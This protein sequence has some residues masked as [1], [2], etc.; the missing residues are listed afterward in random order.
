MTSTNAYE[1]NV[2][3]RNILKFAIPTIIMTIFMSFYTMVD[4]LFVS[5]LLGTDALSAINLTAPIIALVTAVSTMLA[6]DGSAL[7]MKKVGE[8]KGEE[9][10]QDFTFLILVN[11]VVGAIMT[12]VAYL[13]MD[14]IFLSMDL[15]STTFNYCHDYLSH[16]LFFVI[17]ILLMNNFTLYMIA[18]G[19]SNLSILCSI[20][21]GITNIILDYFLIA[22]CHMGIK[23]AAIATGIGYSITAIV[24][25]YI[26][27]KKTEMI[28]FT[29]LKCRLATLLKA[30]TNGSSE[31]ATA[32]VTG[33]T[34]MLFNA[35]MLY[36]V[37][38]D[39][40]AA[41]TIIMY[42]LMFAT[43]LYTGYAYGV[44]PMISYYHGQQNH[45]KLHKLINLSLKI[46]ATVAL[47]SLISSIALTK[48]LV[49]IFT[50]VDNPV[51]QLAVNGNQLCSI[52]IIFIGFN[53]FVSSLFT[54][55][56]NGLISAVIAFSRS[57][58][59]MIIALITLPKLLGINGIWL[60]TPVAELA[61]FILASIMFIIFKKRYRY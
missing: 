43:S 34:T 17:A 49:S 2:N 47:V 35:S 26:F 42:V 13:L 7:I 9:A 22:K 59:F 53:I 60:A 4:G 56:S 61:S 8:G 38:E 55:L 23:G 24:G 33:I 6:S 39:G 27:S 10:K 5:N 58:V 40:V 15:S 36:Y 52:A 37:G 14:K 29:K 25:L 28:H 44:A 51:Y 19:K 30:I 45:E 48:P 20:G 32:L 54:A 50:S 16:Y 41:I 11:V 46:I 12:V 3:V 18:V 31:M 57:F 1:Q 21:G